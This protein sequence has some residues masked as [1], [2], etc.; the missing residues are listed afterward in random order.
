M[1]STNSVIYEE[2]PTAAV[3]AQPTIIP[4]L[5]SEPVADNIADIT[6]EEIQMTQ[7]IANLNTDPEP[8]PW[9]S[10]LSA[11][12]AFIRQMQGQPYKY[13]PDVNTT[14]DGGNSDMT[15]ESTLNANDDIIDITRYKSTNVIGDVSHS[16]QFGRSGNNH[17]Y[18]PNTDGYVPMHNQPAFAIGRPSAKSQVRTFNTT[19]GYSVHRNDGI[20]S[21]SNSQSYRSESNT[22]Y[23]DTT[24]YDEDEDDNNGLTEVIDTLHDKVD[25]VYDTTKCIDKTCTEITEMMA[26]IGDIN[27][28]IH[29]TV[30]DQYSYL[31]KIAQNDAAVKLAVGNQLNLIH[32]E[33]ASIKAEQTS[34]RKLLEEILACVN[35][36][37]GSMPHN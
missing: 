23:R 13:T 8:H 2:E 16:L 24:Y 27:E 21:Q 12:D 36:L 25:E 28:D 32:T 7:A 31:I 29:K 3:A 18:Q 6:D 22:R 20:G 26:S 19:S 10:S 30:K 34:Q 35:F 33:I 9:G 5:P 11:A 15:M 4:R 17:P 14:W 37:T 1:E